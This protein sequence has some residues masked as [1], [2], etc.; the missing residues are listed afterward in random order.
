MNEQGRFHIL[1]IHGPNLDLLGK[2][3]PGIYGTQT[4]P[5]I[6][7]ALRVRVREMGG[8]VDI[9]QSPHEGEIVERIGEALG[10]YDGIIINPAAYTHTSIAIRD[11]ISAV[12]LPTIEVHLS[13]IHARE[14][15]RKHSFI[16]P[17]CVG[18]IS[19]FGARSYFLALTALTGIL[20]KDKAKPKERGGDWRRRDEERRPPSTPE[21]PAG[22][23]AEPPI[24]ESPKEVPAALEEAPGEKP[25]EQMIP[26][27]KGPDTNGEV[28]PHLQEKPR[29]PVAEHAVPPRKRPP[30]RRRS[31]SRR[32]KP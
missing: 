31:S 17:V 11:A 12:G 16:A 22:R 21:S 15:F 25:V 27:P 29:E 30:R 3:E 28:P 20:G 10:Q 13:N 32:G 1:V 19:G 5:D 6:D 14:E 26:S 4:L 23:P 2:R 24:A 9:F 7:A 18:Q 8:L